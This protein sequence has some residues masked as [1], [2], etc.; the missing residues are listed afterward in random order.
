MSSL[1]VRV[2]FHGRNQTNKIVWY[3]HSKRPKHDLFEK[4]VEF[5][6]SVLNKT[7]NDNRMLW[8]K[9][10]IKPKMYRDN[11]Q[12]DGKQ[13]LEEL[14]TFCDRFVANCSVELFWNSSPADKLFERFEG[15]AQAVR[16][17]DNFFERIAWAVRTDTQSVRTADERKTNGYPFDN[18]VISLQIWSQTSR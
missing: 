12:G 11:L 6:N 1:P 15:V 3:L 14:F 13:R 2:Y 18:G 17:D 7:C 5:Y 4:V 16:T 9:R 10:W 8:K